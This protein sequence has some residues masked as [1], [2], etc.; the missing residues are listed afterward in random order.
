VSESWTLV[1]GGGTRVYES[2]FA[3]A[4]AGGSSF[5]QVSD[6]WTCTTGLQQW[7]FTEASGVLSL[8]TVPEPSVLA[9][10]AVG[11]V[12]LLG[13]VWRRRR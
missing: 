8:V 6:V 5:T 7:T 2:S 1:T 3:L 12:G 9:L 4:M 10:L 13:Y 11:I